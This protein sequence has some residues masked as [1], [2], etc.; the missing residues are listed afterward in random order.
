MN[1]IELVNLSDYEIQ[2]V[3]RN[4]DVDDHAIAIIGL[5]KII[6]NFEELNLKFRRNMSI[7][8]TSMLD[9]KIEQLKEESVRVNCEEAQQK[10]A[11]IGEKVVNFE[12]KMDNL[13]DMQIQEI[14]KKISLDELAIV[15]KI[16][17]CRH[18]NKFYR[19]MSKKD[20]EDTKRISEGVKYPFEG[21]NLNDIEEKFINIIYQ[22]I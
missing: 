1:Y 13:S 20:C 14:L 3:L 19:N 2:R 7:R 5:E 22:V 18:Q 15:I 8:A 12:R 21:I 10:I 11:D 16:M 4:I 9:K 17:C 6:A